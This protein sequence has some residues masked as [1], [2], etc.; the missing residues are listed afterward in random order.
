[1]STVSKSWLQTSKDRL[2]ASK[3]LDYWIDVIN[4]DEKPDPV[5]LQACYKAANK[6]MPDRK[7][8]EHEVDGVINVFTK[9][10]LEPDDPK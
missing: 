7:A 8:I 10:Y 2:S 3:M 9:S 1:M 4:G 6:V 5:R